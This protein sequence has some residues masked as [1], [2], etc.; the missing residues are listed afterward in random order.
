MGSAALEEE[1]SGGFAVNNSFN[2]V[3]KQRRADKLHHRNKFQ[4]YAA[5]NKHEEHHG[6][7]IQFRQPASKK[8]TQKQ[9]NSSQVDKSTPDELQQ[10][11]EKFNV[12]DI[13]Y[14]LLAEEIRGI[15]KNS[16][17]PQVLQTIKLGQ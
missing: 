13:R 5:L 3:I 2:G 6:N 4:A 16:F 7:Q 8:A 11:Q 14:R 12:Y 9:E 10:M 15:V 1:C 17:K